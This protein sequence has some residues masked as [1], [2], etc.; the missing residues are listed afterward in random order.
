MKL[1][2]TQQE[3]ELLAVENIPYDNQQDY[4]IAEALELLDLVRNVEVEYAQDYG[5]D[6]EMLYE[7]YCRL[8]DKLFEL[9]EGI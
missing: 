1:D 7:A 2:L 9:L 3:M 5:N 4:T 8:G 6:R